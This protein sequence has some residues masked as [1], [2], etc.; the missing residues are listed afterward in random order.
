[1]HQGSRCVICNMQSV[2]LE[3]LEEELLQN[4]F[5]DNDNGVWDAADQNECTFEDCSVQC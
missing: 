1:M 4:S 2:D 3:I 5:Q